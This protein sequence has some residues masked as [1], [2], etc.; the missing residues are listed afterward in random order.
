M[1]MEDYFMSNGWNISHTT[2]LPPRHK[3]LFGIDDLS[4]SEESRRFLQNVFPDGIYQHQKIAIQHFLSGKNICMTTG[5]ASGKSLSFYIAAIEELLKH[6]PSR[7]IAIYPLKALG[8]EQ[9]DRW[10]DA[11]SNAGV[12]AEV[13]RIDGQ[14]PMASRPAILRNAKVLI[15]TP[16]I[17][18]AWLL[19]NL[20]DKSV[21]N[22]LQCV[23]LIVVDE[24]HNY[25]GVFGSNAAFL[26]R[27][28]Q[29][30]M[31]LLGASPKYI[32]ASATISEP[33]EHLRNLFGLDFTLIG[34][35]FDT[36]PKHELEIQ[37]VVPPRSADLL[38]EV[39]N[40]LYYLAT[41]TSSRFIAFVDSRKQTEHISSIL[42][43]SQDKE[44]ER[45]SEFK[46]DHLERLNVLPYRAGYEEH[47]RDIIQKRLS[48]GTLR[49]VVSTSALEL[50]IDIPFLD[51]GVL[52]G[53]PHS[54]T[55][56]LQR[57]GRIGRHSSGTIMVVNTGDVY[58]EAIFKNPEGFLSRPMA[59]SAL[60][61]ENIRIQYIHALCLA[62]HGGE[63]DQICSSLSLDEETEFSSPVDWPDGFIDLCKRERL[64]EIPV[65]L[66]S[67]KSESGDDPNHTFPL[68]DVE[69]QF[70]VE[71]KQGPELRSLGS[72][73]YGQLMREAYPGAVYYYTTQPF[74]V[75]RVYIHS[76]LV[77]VR[78]E[79]RYT[80]RPQA[81]PTL[82]FPNLTHGNVYRSKKYSDLIVAECNL[83]IRE[84][85]CGFKERRG[86]NEFT[87]NYPPDSAETGV[88]FNLPRFTG[89]YFTTGVVITHPALNKER[90]NCEA[91]ANLLY[92]V[93]L[94]L[95]PFERRDIN[96][97]A[98]KHRAK[99]GPLEEG[100]RFVAIYDQTYGSLRLSGRLLERDIL[101]RTFE[102]AVE[103]AEHRGVPEIN[104][105]TITA[106]ELLYNSLSQEGL[107]LSFEA[108][109]PQ[110]ISAHKYERVIL[111]GS[112]G[113]NIN[114]HNEEFWVEDVF[115]HPS[116]GGLCYRGRHVSTT[117]ETVKEIIPIKALV[118][119]P[120]E[121]KTA[122]YD[123]DTGE[124]GAA[125]SS[126]I[127]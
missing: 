66:Q 110:Q 108:D 17:I 61:L 35:E 119:I 44:E 80:T 46:L 3:R 79:K 42:A 69:S 20:S 57:I 67:M 68:R 101:Q 92:E 87:C 74:R 1:N 48:K 107:D 47:D 118:E 76:K 86:P 73:S 112:K 9:E 94:I 117:E 25:T 62:R 109:V 85:I 75:Y 31:N 6:T 97:A 103:L 121:S 54:T 83:Q 28:I 30:L 22:F 98:D 18:H 4:I 40:L 115:F 26:F 52:I 84:T 2:K 111:P 33:S 58:D 12:S 23:S 126:D 82:V 77:Q 37:L 105:E 91:L 21:L 89:N 53:V 51:I 106:I 70:K 113:L 32:C 15:L 72:L 49:G 125:T 50:G 60:Y 56:L 63:H 96:F 39:S 116:I 127:S 93:F 124:I 14:V 13:D 11:L 99:R 19:S 64:G 123:Y 10:K 104:S 65:D 16:D 43:R 59:E 8:R 34:P 38:T 88:Y 5:A 102:G 55:S 120:G 29:H 114:R 45:E 7:I 81:L 95:I 71:L 100:S 41:Q 36:S 90:V 24:V 78:K 27:R 122:L